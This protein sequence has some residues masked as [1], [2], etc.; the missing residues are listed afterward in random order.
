MPAYN[1]VSE[2]VLGFES[3]HSQGLI[4]TELEEVLEHFKLTHTLNMDK[5]YTAMYANTCMVIE[6]EIVSYHQ[7]VIHGIVCAIED[8]ELTVGEWD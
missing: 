3:K 5:Y 2:Y 4:N 1:E 6:G 8:R 7:D